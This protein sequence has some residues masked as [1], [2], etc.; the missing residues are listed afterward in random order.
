[1]KNSSIFSVI[2][3]WLMTPSR[4]GLI[5]R[6]LAGVR[7]IMSWASLPMQII[8]PVSVSTATTDGSLITISFPL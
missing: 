6:I 8:S 2:S 3:Y 4:I 7:P 1:M 5:V